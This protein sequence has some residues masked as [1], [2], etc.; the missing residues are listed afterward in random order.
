[1]TRT[2]IVMDRETKDVLERTRLALLEKNRNG[3]IDGDYR[4]WHRATY[5]AIIERGIRLAAQEV[6]VLD[7]AA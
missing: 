6:G 1:M 3:G 2:T 7:V 5:T 4:S